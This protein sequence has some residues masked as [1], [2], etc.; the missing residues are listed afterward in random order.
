MVTHLHSEFKAVGV[1]V[2]PVLH[3]SCHAV[4]VSAIGDAVGELHSGR[5]AGASVQ[6]PCVGLGGA[7]EGKGELLFNRDCGFWN[8][9]HFPPIFWSV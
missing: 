2:V 6:H 3:A 4:P 8:T 7:G 1:E 9:S 5:V